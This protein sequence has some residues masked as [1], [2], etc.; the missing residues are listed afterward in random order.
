MGPRMI[1]HTHT[2]LLFGNYPVLPFLVFLDFLVFSP[3]EEFLGFLTVFPLFPGI[4]GARWGWKI[5]VFWVVFLAVFHK[6]QGREGQ[7][8]FPIAQHS[9]CTG[10]CGRNCVI[11]GASIP[12][13]PKCLQYKNKSCEEF[14]S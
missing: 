4:L 7:G 13:T 14:I 2:S 1:T 12:S 9:R 6:K 3:C 8:K 10:L 5:L 11:P